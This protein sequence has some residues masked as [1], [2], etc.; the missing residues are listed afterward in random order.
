MT[1]YELIQ[2]LTNYPHDTPVYIHG[3]A[4]E[5][6]DAATANVAAVTDEEQDAA[7]AA[8]NHADNT[9]PVEAVE[10]AQWPGGK[11]VIS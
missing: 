6:C 10:A 3:A 7:D 11:V 5:W 1:I 4:R 9:E 2:Q 8:M